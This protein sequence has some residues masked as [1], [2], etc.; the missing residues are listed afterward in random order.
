MSDTTTKKPRGF[1]AL[2][3]EKRRAIA[4]KGGRKSQA[5]GKGHRFTKGD[6]SAITAGRKGGLKRGRSAPAVSP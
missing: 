2:S 1:A 6:E 3:V 5:C 4:A